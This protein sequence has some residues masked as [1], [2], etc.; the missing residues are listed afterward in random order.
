MS[1]HKHTLLSKIICTLPVTL[2]LGLGGCNSSGSSGTTNTNDDGETLSTEAVGYTIP[3]EVSAVPVDN[4][5]EQARAARVSRAFAARAASTLPATSDY[6]LAVPR[7]YIEERSLDQFDILEQV[8]GAFAQT[9]FAD[10]ENIN[11]GP[12]KAMVAWEEESDGRSVKQLQPWVVDSRMIVDAEGRDVNRVLVWIEESNPDAVDGKELIKAEIK[13]YESATVDA[14]GT[15]TDYGEWD[16][17][18]MFGDGE[19]DYFTA[20]SST[21]DGVNVVKVQDHFM[22]GPPGG[23]VLISMK[24]V[25]YR[26][27]D[28]GYG[29]VQYPDW[30]SCWMTG[31]GDC[32]PESV[33]AQYSY[34]DTYMAV[35]QE[36][37]PVAYRSRAST[38]DMT[39]KYALFY[40]KSVV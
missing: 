8:L 33:V 30:E 24:G 22:E 13:V 12:Y 10:A 19:D 21:E 17:N 18:V 28:V 9:H 40:R 32:V 1:N 34:N 6:A 15:V 23:E 37:D 20:S 7:R 16:M 2:A 36:D 14:D 29:K 31:P 35:Q 3:T 25:L 38:T 26:S 11:A 39:H 4:G 27:G 5:S